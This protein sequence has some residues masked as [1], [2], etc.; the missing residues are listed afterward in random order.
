MGL[1][2]AADAGVLETA[3]SACFEELEAYVD[4]PTENK[5]GGP[6]AGADDFGVVMLCGGVA[7]VLER[8]AG[9]EA[10]ALDEKFQVFGFGA[11]F[12]MLGL[13]V[14]ALD[15]AREVPNLEVV[16][17]LV[18]L[19]LEEAGVC[20]RTVLLIGRLLALVLSTLSEG[21]LASL[22]TVDFVLL[23]FVFVDRVL[24]LGINV[25]WEYYLKIS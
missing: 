23:H 15:L 22:I 20:L 13:E 5:E 8:D 2:D 16:L 12:G 11:A 9:G 10:D 7:G 3:G 1:E 21:L 19:L 14:G 17:M 4:F 24:I 25:K 18:E 6:S